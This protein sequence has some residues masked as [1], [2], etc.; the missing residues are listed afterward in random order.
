[1]IRQTPKDA[2][3]LTFNPQGTLSYEELASLLHESRKVRSSKDSTCCGDIVTPTKFDVLCGRDFESHSHEGN[4]RFRAIIVMNCE[5]YQNAKKRDDKYSI[6]D[7]IV[8]EIGGCFL[9]KDPKTNM[10]RDI[11]RHSAHEKVSHALRS[12]KA[13]N[14]PKKKCPRGTRTIVPKDAAKGENPVYDFLFTQQQ[15]IFRELLKAEELS[16]KELSSPF[17]PSAFRPP[18]FEYQPVAKENAVDKMPKLEPTRGR[19]NTCAAAAASRVERYLNDDNTKEGTTPI[20]D[21]VP[22]IEDVCEGE[23]DTMATVAPSEASLSW[24]ETDMEDRVQERKKAQDYVTI[25]INKPEE[26]IDTEG[27]EKSNGAA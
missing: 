15:C 11:G 3:S 24:G 18:Q 19:E 23:G 20:V 6:T 5:R 8:N 10:W 4:R 13:P 9:R 21:M 16:A 25:I 22:R 2:E 17:G 27:H 26:S 14:T 1:M 12:A 7:E